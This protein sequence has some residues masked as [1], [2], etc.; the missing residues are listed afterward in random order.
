[1]RE[2]IRAGAL[3]LPYK[4]HLRLIS[5][6]HKFKLSMQ[7]TATLSG[8]FVSEVCLIVQVE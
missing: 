6:L 4:N 5:L 7:E 2:D 3:I 8:L 1:M